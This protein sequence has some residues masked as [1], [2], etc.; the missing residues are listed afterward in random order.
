MSEATPRPV[1]KHKPAEERRREILDA[2]ALIFAEDGYRGTDVD[3][4]A[5]RAGVG[6]GTVYRLFANKESLFLETVRTAVDDLSEYVNSAVNALDDPMEQL[7]VGIHRYLEFFENNP[8]T[9]ELFIQERAEFRRKSKPLYFVY[10][11]MYGADW[12]ERFRQLI[13]S[14]RMRAVSPELAHSLFADLLYGSVFSQ[15]L[16]GDRASRAGQSDQIIDILFRG[17]LPPEPH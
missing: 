14:G 4:I 3:R 5:D 2:A 6:K 8:G 11:E 7:Q 17:V 1:R 16:A 9:V 10:Q 13:D 12:V 15:R